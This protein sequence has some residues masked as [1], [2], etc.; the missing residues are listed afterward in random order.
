MNFESI[1]HPFLDS[2]IKTSTCT[3]TDWDSRE[4]TQHLTECTFSIIYTCSTRKMIERLKNY[5]C[6]Y[7]QNI[8]I[9][10]Q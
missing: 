7:L 2:G 3:F 1:G 4:W 5:L 8:I 9:S 10:T 6:S